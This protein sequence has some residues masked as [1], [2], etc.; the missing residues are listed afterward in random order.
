MKVLFVAVIV[1]AT[2]TSLLAQGQLSNFQTDENSAVD[3]NSYG[4][5]TVETFMPVPDLIPPPGISET[6]SFDLQPV[7]EPSTFAFA[8]LSLG[9]TAIACKKR[10]KRL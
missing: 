3:Y 8:I 1:S 7:P 4:V 10:I 6:S 5:I 2:A 9:L